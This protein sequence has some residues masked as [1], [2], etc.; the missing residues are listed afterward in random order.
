[1][2]AAAKSN[3]PD[4]EVVA[5]GGDFTIDP[6]QFYN[7]I[8][9]KSNAQLEAWGGIDGV[10]KKLGSDLERGIP[11]SSIAERKR[12]YGVNKLPVE[13]EVTYWKYLKEALSDKM[14]ILLLVLG[15]IALI[16][17]LSVPEQGHDDVDY[18]KAWIDG[19]FI[20]V[21]VTIVILVTTIND[22][23]K[24]LKFA[25]LNE[26]TSKCPAQVL[27]DGVR[28]KIDVSELVV[29]DVVEFSGGT[30]L[31]S[32]G[33][34]LEGQ[35]VSVDEAA[36]TGEN[37]DKKKDCEKDPFII[38]GTNV[39]AGEHAK[40]L[41]VGVGV[42][43]FSGRLEMEARENGKRQATPLQEKLD[44][45]ADLV[46]W[47]G[48][49]VAV[50]LFVTLTTIT[51]IYAAANDK[52]YDF[53]LLLDFAIIGVSI[54]VVAVPEGLPLSV[55]IALA[56][57]MQAMMKDNNMVRS[58]A[59]CET[60]GAATSICSDKT[61]TLTTNEMTQISATIGTLETKP[62]DHNGTG[63]LGLGDLHDS[64]SNKALQFYTESVIFNTTAEKIPAPQGTKSKVIDGHIWIGNK[65]EMGLL[66][67]AERADPRTVAGLR[68]SVGAKDRLVYP[69]QSKKKSMTTLVRMQQQHLGRCV[70]Q[71]TKGASE[72]VLENS[73][74]YMNADGELLPMTDEARAD[75]MRGITAYATQGLRTLAIAMRR[76]GDYDT[77]FP[78]ED[79][80]EPNLVFLGF[81]GIEDPVRDEV[82]GAVANCQSA[83]VTVRMCTGD[84]ID[85]AKAISKKCGIYTDGGVA[86]EGPT[87][88]KMFCDD[89]KAFMEMLPQLQ[90]LA[91]CSP[92]DKQLLV[93]NL[94]LL[95]EVVAVTGDG[96][97][98]AP[99]LKLADVGFAMNDGT[100]VAKKASKIV[101]LDNNFVS[102]VKV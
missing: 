72:I 58:L 1:M 10:A 78:E 13:D 37:D 35:G 52:S 68:A 70:M 26:E 8:Q 44:A 27:R 86:M 99:A 98:D 53:K 15:A 6:K 22:Y 101:L 76:Y 5:S 62:Y 2:P 57:S 87:F 7:L 95:G 33:L 97:N 11:S 50:A 73:S 25:A 92:L 28:Q 64:L 79:P 61:G 31:P 39:L 80:F 40:Y 54:I 18:S 51:A 100:Q 46:G 34:F 81:S 21:A 23:M 3:E 29:G 19:T 93:G 30:F 82:P 96:T 65:T 102:V 41:T 12:V 14:M 24:G 42:E 88:R 48:I 55:V 85:T 4:V 71:Y 32:D 77:P 9:D 94:M 17:G 56:Y 47:V 69:F 43:S 60:M 83:G 49:A 90:V 63:T 59:A 38:S 89:E 66:R 36:A 20:I 74:E 16:I 91:R 67:W 45:L 84:N 75:L